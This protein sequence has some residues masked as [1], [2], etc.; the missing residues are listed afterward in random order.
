MQPGIRGGEQCQRGRCKGPNI[1][2]RIKPRWPTQTHQNVYPTSL[3][4]NYEPSQ[5][6]TVKLKHHRQYVFLT[7]QNPVALHCCLHIDLSTSSLQN[8][9][10]SKCRLLGWWESPIEFAVGICG[11]SS[12]VTLLCRWIKE[13]GC[14]SMILSWCLWESS[15][16]ID[17]QKPNRI[18]SWICIN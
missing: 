14:I 15:W 18:G 7:I 1:E 12:L 2:C 4:R 17:P 6:D 3:L 5:V 11:Q 16:C 9:F 13:C 8:D 10:G